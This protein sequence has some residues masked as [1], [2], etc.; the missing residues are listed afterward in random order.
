MSTELLLPYKGI[1]TESEIKDYQQKTGLVTYASIITRP[2]NAQA[3]KA[4]AE[5][6]KNPGLQHANAVLRDLRYLVGTKYLALE[7]GT[8]KDLALV[9]NVASDA[10]FADDIITR[11]STEG[12]VF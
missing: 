11:R 5:A 2:D 10:S 9:F 12:K 8:L 1:A 3:S 7:L 6:N 4:L